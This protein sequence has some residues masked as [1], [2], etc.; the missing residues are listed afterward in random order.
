MIRTFYL[1]ISKI[2]R[3]FALDLLPVTHMN[4][5]SAKERRALILKQL[6]TK[7]EVL[8]S[9]LSKETGISEVTIRKDLTILQN[10][11]L[12]IRTRGGAIR[13]PI[14][15]LNEDTAI[16]KK[17]MFNFRE[18]ERIGIEA[19][20]LIKEGDYIM[21]DS[22]TTTMEIA[23]NLHKFHNLH[24]VTN[25]LNIAM[26]LMVYKR[27]EVVL[28][29]GHVRLNSY[30]TVGPLALSV[31]RN[32]TEYKLFL[33][34]DS[35][36]LENGISTPNLEEALLNQLMIQQ[37]S[38]VIAVFDSSKFN[39]RSFSFVANAKDLNTIITDSAIP[40]GMATKL[41]AMNIDVRI[42]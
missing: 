1:H 36:S 21:L 39:K 25:A 11:K 14:E 4:L 41:K 3:T 33:G 32:F 42:V 13:K 38:Q 30:S 6:E 16:T 18:K 29:G 20:K 40:A 10:R 19:T 5:S 27:F 34:V 37:A 15:N 9:E 8:V 24:I 31:L 2:F 7:E 26:E 12:L 35:F 22:G 28:I 17:R 23:K